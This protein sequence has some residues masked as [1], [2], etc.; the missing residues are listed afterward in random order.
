ML[1]DRAAVP[2]STTLRVATM[3]AGMPRR[4]GRDADCPSMRTLLARIAATVF[5]LALPL[6]ATA[7]G[8]T[9][10]YTY[11]AAGNIVAIKNVAA[12]ALALT[13]FS[14][15]KAAFLAQ[16]TLSGSGFSLVTTEN[17]VSF[18]GT[19]ANV[20]SASANTLVVT[21]PTNA[22]TGRITVSVGSAFITNPTIFVVDTSLQA[23]TITSF[24]PAI[25]TPGTVVTIHGAN[26][27]PVASNDTVTFNSTPI[28]PSVLNTTQMTGTVPVALSS[29]KISVSTVYGTA[30]SATDLIVVPN[31]YAASAIGTT[32]RTTIGGT[33]ASVSIPI[34]KIGLVLF[35]A[36]QGENVSL[37]IT[38]LVTS[39]AN[40][41]LDAVLITPTGATVQIG[42][43]CGG[44][45]A[46]GIFPPSS[47]CYLS[48]LS[49][50][51]TYTLLFSSASTTATTFKVSL[52]K[53]ITSPL[54]TASQSV[55]LSR[56]AQSERLTFI[57]NEGST[58]TVEVAGITVT[59]ATATLYGALYDPDG[60]A[61]QTIGTLAGGLVFHVPSARVH[62]TYTVFLQADSGATVS[63]HAMLDTGVNLPIDG[64][65][66]TINTTLTGKPAKYTFIATAGQNLGLALGGLTL[67]PTSFTNAGIMLL[68]PDGTKNSSFS[69]YS[70]SNESCQSLTLAPNGCSWNLTNLP[71]TGTY[72]LFFIPGSS[73]VPTRSEASLMSATMTLSSDI[74][75]TLSSGSAPLSVNLTR[76]GQKERLSFP[77]IAGHPTG[78]QVGGVVTSGPTGRGM[79]ASIRD[80]SNTVVQSADS[81]GDFATGGV[82]LYM[83]SP[84]LSGTYT[85]Y[86]EPD[87]A[88]TGSAVVTLGGT[89]LVAD[90]A[91]A[92]ISTTNP[93]LAVQYNFSGTQG[94]NL[95]LAVSGLTLNPTTFNVAGVALYNPDGSAN[96]NINTH[97][98][99]YICSS[100][101]SN[102]SG[103]GWDLPNLP[104]TGIYTFFVIPGFTS[105]A[106]TRA[107]A[108]SMSAT[109]TLSTDASPPLV[110]NTPLP[111]TLRPGKN[112]RL[113][114]NAAAGQPI[115]VEIAGITTA[116]ISAGMTATIYDPSGNY[117]QSVNS[118]TVNNPGGLL[119]YVANPSVIGTYTVVIEPN[120]GASGSATV[121]LDSGTA[122]SINTPAT[123]TTTVVGQSTRFNFSVGT[124]GQNVT[125]ALAGLAMGPFVPNTGGSAAAV[126][127]N[128]D[129]TRNGAVNGC[130]L[131]LGAT[132]SCAWNFSNLA[133]GTYSLLVMPG[134][135]GAVPAVTD[136]LTMSATVTVS[137]QISSTLSSGLPVPLT[138][139]SAGQSERLSV[140][141]TAGQPM[142]IEV[143]GIA[144]VPVAAGMTAILYDPTGIY[145]QGLNSNTINNPGGLLLYVAN[146]STTGA[147]SVVIQPN[148]GAT[149]SAIATLDAGASL[150]VNGS[151]LAVN[152]T[153]IG[154]SRRF[155]FSI[156]TSGQN[157]TFALTGLTLGPVVAN[158]VGI[159]S[160]ALFNPDGTRNGAIT[161][162]GVLLGST[163]SC[164]WNFSNLL[165][166]TYSLIM[167]PGSYPAVPAVT[168]GL[169]INTAVTVSSEIT[170]TLTAGTPVSMNL[171]GP[172]QSARLSFTGTVGMPIA[173]EVAGVTP[174]PASEVLSVSLLGPTGS[175]VVFPIYSSSGG[176]LLYIPS[177]ASTGTY[178]MFAQFSNAATGSAQVT[179]DA[180]TTLL[181]NGTAVGFSTT[182]AGQSR[183]YQFAGTAAQSLTLN[184]TSLS[185]ASAGGY[186]SVIVYSP[187]GAQMIYAEPI[188]FSGGNGQL[189]LSNLPATGTYTVLL[190]PG[191]SPPNTTA[192]TMSGSLS[193]Q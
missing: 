114:I 14:P 48:T 42:Q 99:N 92:T 139:A 47:S 123:L 70:Y 143:A 29:G 72:T 121:T 69:A 164:A 103:C 41:G 113:I 23:P 95:G 124:A 2:P 45:G 187:T 90:G 49:S 78:I 59:P 183:V 58:F 107:D 129:G 141:A 36:V 38:N 186:A 97:T 61:I 43:H 6:F 46:V 64:A 71:Q 171:A 127:F 174:S 159:V 136:G 142:V 119:L 182:V 145:V 22:R 89:S 5:L 134:V 125:V 88:A 152:T 18:N 32:P 190:F 151:A 172:G 3:D 184:L 153:A 37:G 20:V 108:A 177:A 133:A 76:P 132:T 1:M 60:N 63:A 24:S 105:S 106:P 131:V 19:L 57:Q 10:R 101:A 87:G 169:T 115:A 81:F 188:A 158:T 11:D 118:N 185:M 84:S 166:G 35:D 144:T 149:G 179:L 170:S 79:T 50:T 189:T 111:I 31:Y 44:S 83:H 66:A 28:V 120:Y 16:V 52:T 155:N 94:Q 40:T 178:T 147:Y 17:V 4:G 181:T 13:S 175:Q 56:A 156:P 137:G 62:G 162:C 126:L 51:G 9:H 104:Q 53:E 160:G 130:Y 82:V 135:Y 12:D 68:N 100:I 140:T 157:A 54:T 110:A 55:S 168:D 173:V 193:L 33:P 112:E 65:T 116:P 96:S 67:T 93:G 30:V 77:V 15:T 91:P 75:G 154:Q 146:P 148:N 98:N 122:L 109:V 21:V 25:V 161:S 191:N 128:P 73:G 102:P 176:V 165:A 85:L 26:Y 167:M 74:S 163:T 117:V 8:S 34:G 7:V 192:F 39:P 150:V 138:L 80:P 180:G 86:L 27:D